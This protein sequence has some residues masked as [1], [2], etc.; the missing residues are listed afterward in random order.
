MG[1]KDKDAHSNYS[2]GSIQVHRRILKQIIQI[3]FGVP[4]IAIK[5]YP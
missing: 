3:F 2:K 4:K 1:Q 5:P